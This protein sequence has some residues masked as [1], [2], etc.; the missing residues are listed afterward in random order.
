MS[1][2]TL[3]TFKPLAKKSLDCFND[4]RLLVLSQIRKNRDRY[5][6]R[7]ALFTIGEITSFVSQFGVAFLHVQGDRIINRMADLFF[8]QPFHKCVAAVRGDSV[9]IID[10]PAVGHP[11]RQ[12]QIADTGEFPV[13]N[14]GMFRPRLF[15][16]ANS[17]RASW[18]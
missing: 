2:S 6:L 12:F 7:G 8:F 17:L 13:I 15:N 3:Y 18:V 9:L 5:N 1:R 16:S 4:K 11:E 10:M 14:S